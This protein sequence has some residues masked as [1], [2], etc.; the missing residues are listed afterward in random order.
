M[1]KNSILDNLL[2]KLSPKKKTCTKNKTFAN[3]L[4]FDNFENKTNVKKNV[5]RE[6]E[7]TKIFS[8]IEKKEIIVFKKVKKFKHNN[9]N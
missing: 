1:F 2:D 7:E 6:I 3:K 5:E 4:L 9:N 8:N